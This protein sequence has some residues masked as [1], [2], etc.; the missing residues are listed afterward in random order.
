MVEGWGEVGGGRSSNNSIASWGLV[1]SKRLRPAIH[2]TPRPGGGPGG[3]MRRE[4]AQD[5]IGI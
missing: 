1:N 5:A 4:E 3:G 2:Q